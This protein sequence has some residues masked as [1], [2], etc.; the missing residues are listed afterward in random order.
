MKAK[1]IYDL[2]DRDDLLAH[3][4]A[5]KSTEMA[6]VIWEML[7]NSYK[8]L[9]KYTEV[10]DDYANGVEDAIDYMIGLCEENGININDLID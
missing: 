2:S 1:I 4:R 9:T 8:K 5:V 6:I 10:S 3:L 7:N